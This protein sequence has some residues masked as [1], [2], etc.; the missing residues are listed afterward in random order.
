MNLV[1]WIV[2]GVLALAMLGAGGM[3]LARSRDQLREAGMG[4]VDDFSPAAVK[5]IG[6]A[7]VAGALGLVL[8]P[9]VDVATWLA[10]LAAVGLLLTMLGAVVVHLRRGETPMLVPPL[11]LGVLAAVVAWGRFGPYPFG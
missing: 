6:A 4:W 3:K 5:A 11:V 2:A 9:L 8:P 7:E 10:P 1:L